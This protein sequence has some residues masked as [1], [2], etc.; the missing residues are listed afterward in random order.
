MKKKKLI[1]A[2]KQKKTNKTKKIKVVKK[3]SVKRVAVVSL[4]VVAVLIIGC[5]SYSFM[6]FSGVSKESKVLMPAEFSGIYLGQFAGYAKMKHPGMKEAEGMED[7]C[8]ERVSNMPYEYVY[9]QY[10]SVLKNPFL[11]GKIT[12]I[13]FNK[14]CAD[15]KLT[16]Q[17]I[18]YWVKLYGKDFKVSK[19][20]LYSKEEQGLTTLMLK[21]EKKDMNLYLLYSPGK[22]GKTKDF[23]Q[24]NIC[25]PRFLNISKILNNREKALTETETKKYLEGFLN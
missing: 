25:D 20:N 24:L 12:A 4:A 3:S 13:K 17:F 14:E 9:L 7:A 16:K 19:V 23:L 18:Q 5:F 1:K 2:K 15:K 21:W 11:C 22:N 6:F 8:V 10:V